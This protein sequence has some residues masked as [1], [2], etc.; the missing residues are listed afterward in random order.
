[1]A[2][3][4]KRRDKK[5]P[6]TAGGKGGQP[7]VMP[8]STSPSQQIATL[9]LPDVSQVLRELEAKLESKVIT[10]YLYEGAQISDDA[11][12]PLYKQLRAIGNQKRL[13]LFIHSRGG[14]TETPWK[15]I[16]M[17]R[18]F[19]EYFAVLVAYRA[20]S[21]ATHIALGANE[22]VMTAF[23]ELGPVDPYR[24]HPLLPTGPDDKPISISVQDMKHC[25]S[26]IKRE[27]ETPYTPEALA[28]LFAAMFE[29]IHPLAM[30]AIE[31]SYALSQIISEKALATHMDAEKD[32]EKIHEIAQTLLDGYKSHRF[33]IGRL[34]ARK[35][36]LSVVDADPEMENL[37]WRLYEL[38]SQSETA[39]PAPVP[40]ARGKFRKIVG[41]IDSVTKRF[42]HMGLF[43]EEKPGFFKVVGGAWEEISL[44]PQSDR[45]I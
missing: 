32:K 15:I 42:A 5:S 23:A 16:E 4:R 13:N 7:M 19:C 31:Q 8:G 40:N 45:A 43:E 39:L 35:L 20:H 27:A 37:L 34:E 2:A 9:S 18:N 14:A 28:Q 24:T 38:Y 3:K 1:M 36:G 11:M 25:I 33:Q 22:I 26:F 10:Y 6:I 41:H 21:A 30:G 12:I 17:F 44:P 29:K